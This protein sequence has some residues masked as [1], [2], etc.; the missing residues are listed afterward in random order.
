MKKINFLFEN[1]LELKLEF[2]VLRIHSF[3]VQ[4]DLVTY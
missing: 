1:K 2:K 4:T 3:L